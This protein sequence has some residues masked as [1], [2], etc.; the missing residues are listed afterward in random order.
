MCSIDESNQVHLD[1][2][3][4][5]FVVVLVVDEGLAEA[6]LERVLV[7]EFGELF[8][9]NPSGEQRRQVEYGL[10]LAARHDDLLLALLEHDVYVLVACRRLDVEDVVVRA[11]VDSHAKLEAEA[12]IGQAPAALCRP[13]G[14]D[15][16]AEREASE[17]RGVEQTV[18]HEWHARHHHGLLDRHA[19]LVVLY[20]EDWA[21][22]K[23][24]SRAN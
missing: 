22:V 21:Q 19:P 7:V 6:Y 16:A 5:L 3:G 13:V 10:G 14:I 15:A 2:A 17:P 11:E 20:A 23:S 12:Q 24:H 8:G 4:R 9:H 1:P 18:D